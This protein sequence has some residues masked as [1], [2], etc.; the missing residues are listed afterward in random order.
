MDI[1]INLAP[2]VLAFLVCGALASLVLVLGFTLALV[3]EL[4]S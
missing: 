3:R 4:R 1:T 2:A